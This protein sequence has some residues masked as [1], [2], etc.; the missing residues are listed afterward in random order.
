[1]DKT[2]NDASGIKKMYEM[3]VKNKKNNSQIEICPV[4]KDKRK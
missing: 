4:K 1:M 2:R 3:F